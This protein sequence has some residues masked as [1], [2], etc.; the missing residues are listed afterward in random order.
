MTNNSCNQINACGPASASF[1][2]HDIT[3][4]HS[5]SATQRNKKI[6]GPF[7]HPYFSD[8]GSN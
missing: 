3:D 5:H 1:H 4:L 2:D 7:A 8:Y 6:I